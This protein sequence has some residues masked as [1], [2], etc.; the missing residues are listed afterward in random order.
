MD[1]VITSYSALHTTCAA[2]NRP[3]VVRFYGSRY[4]KCENLIIDPLVDTGCRSV[5]LGGGGN[6]ATSILRMQ[7]L[8]RYFMSG[9]RTGLTRNEEM[10]RIGASIP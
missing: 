7:I 1:T 6:H 9:Y 3:D 4:R 10:L 8:S 2:L 5:F